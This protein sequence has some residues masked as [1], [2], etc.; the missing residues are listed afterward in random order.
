MSFFT[1]QPSFTLDM[2]LPSDELMPRIRAAIKQPDLRELARSAG[3]C[4]ELKVAFDQQRFWSP[5]LNVQASDV[6][7]G[8]QLYC[9]YSPRPEVWTMFMA[10]YLVVACLIFAACI[11]GYVQWYLD[12]TPW[13]L[14]FIPIGVIGILALH[15][16][17]LAGQRLSADQMDELRGRLDELLSRAVAD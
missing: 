9:R 3:T 17:S 11:Y 7:S 5:Q 4:L 1:V 14:L 16:M 10:I 13:S 2:P 12:D 15:L 6:D 8:S